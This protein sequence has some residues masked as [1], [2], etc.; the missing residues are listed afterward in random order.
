[1][2]VISSLGWIVFLGAPG[3][4]KGTQSEYLVKDHN[5]TVISVGDLLRLNKTQKI[6][7]VVADSG[8]KNLSV[9]DKKLCDDG[10]TIETL[11]KSGSLFPDWIIIDLVRSEVKKAAAAGSRGILFDGFPRTVV[12]AEALSNL[13]KEF[14]S[15]VDKVLNFVVDDAI[16]TKRILGRFKCTHCGK[17]YNDFFLKTKVEGVCD[18]CG[19]KDFERRSDDNEESLKKRLDEYKSKTQDVVAFY[20]KSGALV[21]ID[22]SKSSEDVKNEVIKTISNNDQGS[23]SLCNGIVL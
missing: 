22:A 9:E 15:N 10:V 17:I 20:S 21:N 5:F 12:Q 7:D 14:N 4:G 6:S 8:H 18:D 3:C 11:M 1:M 2:S 16:I 19:H 23:E 13:A